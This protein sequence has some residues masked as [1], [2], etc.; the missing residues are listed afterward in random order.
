MSAR[1]PSIEDFD[2]IR[3]RIT[4]IKQERI[5]PAGPSAAE[6]LPPG[7]TELEAFWARKVITYGW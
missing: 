2:F 4:E 5:A 1:V 7:Q 6:P 3:N